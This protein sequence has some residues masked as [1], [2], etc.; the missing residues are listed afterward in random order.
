MTTPTH[1]IDTLAAGL[2]RTGRYATVEQARAELLAE[3]AWREAG[4]TD[5]RPTA[6]K[7]AGPRSVQG[8]VYGCADCPDVRGLTHAELCAHVQSLHPERVW[9]KR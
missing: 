8:G 5:K 3:Q 2:V 1:H 4:H 6:V 7:T 9:E